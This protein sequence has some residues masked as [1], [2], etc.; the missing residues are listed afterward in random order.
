MEKKVLEKYLADGLSLAQIGEREG[1]D[2]STIGYWVKKHGLKSVHS[3]KYAPRGAVSEEVLTQLVEEGTSV[4]EIARRLN[5]SSSTV[6][7][8]LRRYRLKPRRQ[9]RRADAERARELGMAEVH[10]D[11]GRHGFTKHILEGRGA[12]RCSKCRS[13]AVVR[14]RRNAKLRLVKEAGGRCSLCGFDEFL[15]A[16]QFHHLDPSE[17]SFGL[18]MG[19]LTRSIDKLRTEAAKCILLCANCH[20]KVEWGT[21]EAPAV[22]T[23]SPK[24][25]PKAEAPRRGFAPRRLP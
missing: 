21:A 18:A 13:E 22:S 15:G 5:R 10:L 14:W 16:L 20:A 3:E 6:Y 19:G 2:H 11:C 24:P 4:S 8:W 9:A 23:R 25:P 1:K 7:Y 12:Y 17:K